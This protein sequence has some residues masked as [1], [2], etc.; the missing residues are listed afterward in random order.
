MPPPRVCDN[1]AH[2]C[3]RQAHRSP[4]WHSKAKRNR[5]T[6]NFRATEA[7]KPSQD[8]MVPLHAGDPRSG[9]GHLLPTKKEFAHRSSANKATHSYATHCTDPAN[10]QKQQHREKQ[11]LHRP[12]NHPET[13]TTGGMCGAPSRSGVPFTAIVDLHKGHISVWSEGEVRVCALPPLSGAAPRG[14]PSRHAHH[15]SVPS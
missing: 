4:S 5:R 10:T 12:R 2:V 7:N 9:L 1:T 15:L 14:L 8:W 11:T 13:R 3:E 6:P